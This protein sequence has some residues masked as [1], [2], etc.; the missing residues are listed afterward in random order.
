MTW[1]GTNNTTNVEIAKQMTERRRL[2]RNRSDRM[3]AGVLGGLAEY[4]NID[5]SITR[6]AY[7]V[8]TLLT[9][10]VPGLVLYV[11]MLIVIPAEPAAGE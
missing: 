2:Y 3:I 8:L 7:L 5:P 9:G 10:F 1:G 11:L 4:W 6:I